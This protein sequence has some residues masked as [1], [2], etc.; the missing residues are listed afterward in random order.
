MAITHPR[1]YSQMVERSKPG[2]LR[3]GEDIP[4]NRRLPYI[5]T[6]NQ[7]PRTSLADVIDRYEDNVFLMTLKPSLDCQCIM[8]QT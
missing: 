6:D 7:S 4:D 5:V 1:S 3:S 2:N 8:M